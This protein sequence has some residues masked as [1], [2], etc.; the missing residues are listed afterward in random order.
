MKIIYYDNFTQIERLTN[1]NSLTKENKFKSGTEL[2]HYL[3]S[4]FNIDQYELYWYGNSPSYMIIALNN[5]LIKFYLIKIK[6][7]NKYIL[8]KKLFD[9]GLI[10]KRYLI[11]KNETKKDQKIQ[12]II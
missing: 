10:S 12:W 8:D 7:L 1:I 5:K 4:I 11:D 6:H 2:T 3:N 9:E